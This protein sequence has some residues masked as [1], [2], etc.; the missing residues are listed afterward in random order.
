MN[1]PF[2]ALGTGAKESPIVQL[3]SQVPIRNFMPATLTHCPLNGESPARIK[4]LLLSRVSFTKV[5]RTRGYGPNHSNE[6][7][8]GGHEFSRVSSS[9]GNSLKCSALPIN[10]KLVIP[11][12]D[13]K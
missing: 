12:Y 6:K 9:T 13:S 8:F 4:L 1:L 7:L 10:T 2:L 3:V 11:G 5:S